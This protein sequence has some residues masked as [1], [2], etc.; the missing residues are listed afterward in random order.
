VLAAVVPHGNT[1]IAQ[2]LIGLGADVNSDER[3]HGTPLAWA[4]QG[5]HD[6]CIRLLVDAG[7]SVDAREGKIQKA[8]E[9]ALGGVQ[10]KDSTVALLLGVM[11]HRDGWADEDVRQRREANVQRRLDE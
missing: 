7:A 8:V 1:S 10:C 6:D 9:A 3:E 2:Y 11:T 4:A 5:S